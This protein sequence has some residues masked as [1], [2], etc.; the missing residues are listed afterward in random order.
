M[1]QIEQSRWIDVNHCKPI[2]PSFHVHGI[3][4]DQQSKLLIG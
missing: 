2:T 4:Q 1:L 3:Y